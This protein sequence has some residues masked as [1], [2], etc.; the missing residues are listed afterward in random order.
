MGG[1][2]TGGT[3]LHLSCVRVRPTYG[4]RSKEGQPLAFHV[5]QKASRS[6]TASMAL[7]KSSP[8]SPVSCK[9]FGVGAARRSGGEWGSREET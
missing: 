1:E 7:T 4:G 8:P 2:Q 3:P 9:S 5:T 6:S